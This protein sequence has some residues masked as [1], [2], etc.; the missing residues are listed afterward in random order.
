MLVLDADNS[1][2]MLEKNSELHLKPASNIKLF[3]TGISLLYLGNDY[4]IKTSVYFNKEEITGGEL[5]GDIYIKGFGNALFNTYGLDYMV[6][7]IEKSGI[8]KIRG[9]IIY[10]NSFFKILTSSKEVSTSLSPLDVP[11]I[12]PLS[13]NRNIIELTIT[14]TGRGAK[15]YS[16]PS[17]KYI[18]IINNT[19]AVGSKKAPDALLKEGEK[20]YKIIVNHIPASPKEK[21]IYFFLK[22]PGKLL[23]LLLMERLENR[24]IKLSQQPIEGKI[25]LNN[26]TE[27]SSSISLADFIKETNKKSN[28]FLADEL[29]NIFNSRFCSEA[30]IRQ[31]EKPEIS[32]LK[33]LRIPTEGF[34]FTDGSGISP[35]NRIT[36]K[37]LVSLL[38]IIYN[39]S[40]LYKTFK[41]SLSVAGVD[42]TMKER[43]LNSPIKNHFLG[44]TGF[45]AGTS[46]ISGYMRTK[47]G[48]NIIISILINYKQKGMEYYER[49]EKEILE[50]V[51]FKY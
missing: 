35:R 12:S 30:G 40:E 15:L 28:N 49:I 16:F 45:M 3:T 46:S 5:K 9:K 32:F 37:A 17:S 4:K 6:N 31:R 1:R 14:G 2:I 39:K 8:K 23:A 41:E 29:K 42:G 20:E 18:T 48:K 25:P 50:M 43:F 26:L 19:S 7:Q 47:G 38:S 22:N 10:D 13:I 36:A 51:Y 44:K 21:K 27:I 11:A 24:G 33:T 34:N